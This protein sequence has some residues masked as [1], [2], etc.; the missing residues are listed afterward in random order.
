MSKLLKNCWGWGKQ[1]NNIEEGGKEIHKER[2][3]FFAT[4]L[5]IFKKIAFER[6]IL[7]MIVEKCPS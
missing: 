5:L 3:G 6:N 1:K 4:F 7:H 2:E